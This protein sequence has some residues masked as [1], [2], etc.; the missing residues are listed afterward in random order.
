VTRFDIIGE[1][2]VNPGQIIDADVDTIVQL[3]VLEQTDC[4]CDT[5]APSEEPT[6]EPLKMYLP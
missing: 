4:Y 6:Q 3:I 2:C 1:Y 5:T